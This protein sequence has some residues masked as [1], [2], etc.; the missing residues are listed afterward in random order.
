MIGI[1]LLFVT[2]GVVLV[3]ILIL[4]TN[5]MS[6]LRGLST[7]QM[8]WVE[9]RINSTNTLIRYLDTGDKEEL[10]RFDHS[11]SRI[12]SASQ[13]RLAV[14]A[15]K[16]DY[17]R[18]AAGLLNLDTH[19]RDLGV[20]IS[21][22][23]R[24]YDINYFADAVAQWKHAESL[25]IQMNEMAT[26]IRESDSPLPDAERQELIG[27]LHDMADDMRGQELGLATALSEGTHLLQ[28][29]IITI[30]LL[31]VGALL[32]SGFLYSRRF[33]R[34]VKQWGS[35]LD[36]SEQQYKSLFERNPNAVF[37]M[38]PDGR[39]SSYNKVFGD[40]FG[41]PQSLPG[42]RHADLFLTQT[43]A[44]PKPDRLEQVLSGEPRSF[45]AEWIS[46]SG[47]AIPMQV[48][49]LPIFVDEE[50][51]GAYVIAEDIS[52][53]TYAKQ[54]IEA[55]LEEKTH[56]LAEVHDRVKNNLALIS[57]LLQIQGQYITDNTAL[58]YLDNTISRIRSMSL[59]HENIYQAES[60]ATIRVDEFVDEFAALT[61]RDFRSQN[62]SLTVANDTEPLSMDIKRAIPFGLLLNELINNLYA[63]V[64][65]PDGKSTLKVR[66][67]R[68]NDYT[69]LILQDNQVPI[70]PDFDPAEAIPMGMTLIHALTDQLNASFELNRDTTFSLTVTFRE[71]G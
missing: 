14:I 12:L 24:V 69:E 49:T 9:A 39:I 42:H 7:L 59:V 15:E 54:K 48:T 58:E 33:L 46:R 56:L 30:S 68:R 71:R 37:S 35:A 11:M 57:S 4:A 19:P 21:T 17:D 26:E 67:T 5:T 52:Y 31:L 25:L 40:L 64:M 61:E 2:L 28:K 34:A 44:T 65:I 41:T 55:Q 3:T 60:F 29:L 22:F 43:S 32:T 50:I 36:V 20:M 66:L 13:M 10:E 8:H 62:S 16:T 38:T 1:L 63:S 6:G 18:A 23:E 53:Q 51:V 47:D 70:P 27:Q 45:K